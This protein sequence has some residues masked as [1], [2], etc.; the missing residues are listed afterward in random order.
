MDLSFKDRL[1]I[2]L[3]TNTAA[4]MFKLWFKTCPVK[5]TRPELYEEWA[6][7]DRQIIAATWHRSAV[8]FVYFFGFLKPM[9]MFSRSK[10]GEYLTRFA[11]KFGVQPA[12]GSSSR[13]GAEGLKEMITHL[14]GGGKA[15]ATVMDGPRGPARVAKK[16]LIVLAME[17]GVPLIPI[18]W[19][20]R[21]VWTFKKS[22]DQTMIPKPFSQI[23]INCTDPISIPPDLKPD[24]LEDYRLKFEQILNTLTDEVD[25]MCGYHPP[26]V[27]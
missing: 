25:Q 24:E 23:I 17:T 11:Q 18:I 8:F 26:S 2:S 9:I 21:R 19:S 4:A 10:D 27:M 12:R 1:A 13:G 6:F 20:A 16:G 7:S 5:I 3:A 22:W 14:K 15:C